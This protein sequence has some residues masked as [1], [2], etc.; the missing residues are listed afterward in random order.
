[1]VGTRLPIPPETCLEDLAQ[2]VRRLEKLAAAADTLAEKER[3]LE[4]AHRRVD[5]LSR[6]LQRAEQSHKRERSELDKASARLRSEIEDLR[7]ELHRVRLRVAELEDGQRTSSPPP[8]PKDANGWLN[9]ATLCERLGDTR[10][11][12]AA[13]ARYAAGMRQRPQPAP[14]QAATI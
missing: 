6:Q 11:A 13:N 9:L 7:G 5:E 1:M 12:A 3:E 10:G 8:A 2:K 4:T 14:H